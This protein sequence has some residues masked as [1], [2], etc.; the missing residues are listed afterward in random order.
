MERNEQGSPYEDGEDPEA[1]G[2]KSKK[3]H[4]RKHE[5]HDFCGI[6]LP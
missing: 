2:F 5:K 4:E 3:F 6:S 1:V